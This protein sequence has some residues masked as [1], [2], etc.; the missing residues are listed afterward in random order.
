[1]NKGHMALAMAMMFGRMGESYYRPGAGGRRVRVKVKHK[2][3]PAK[4]AERKRA[5]QSRRK[6]R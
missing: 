3:N 5:K 4:K 6:N 2:A 1:M